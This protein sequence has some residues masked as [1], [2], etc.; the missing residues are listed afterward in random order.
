MI[1]GGKVKIGVL[2]GIGPEAT[3]EFY[4]KLIKKLQ[5]EGLIKKNQDFPQIIINSIPAPELVHEDI[6]KEDLDV[7]IGGLQ[8]LDSFS[9]DI[10]VM[11]CNTIHIYYD[12]LSTFIRAPIIN[13]RNEVKN[14]ILSK[15]YKKI[16]VLG[17]KNTL[18]QGLY[19]FESINTLIPSLEEQNILE[20]AIFNYNLGIEKDKQKK[21]A[22][23]ICKKYQELGI[24]TIILGCTEFAVMLSGLNFS[25][26]NTIDVLVEATLNIFKRRISEE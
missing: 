19:T 2:G 22:E 17:T 3:S 14:E 10:I 9:P 18:K 13:L 21:Q 25:K 23:E 15:D 8:E 7:Y 6:S 26:I 20:K 24:K 12:Y 1:F 5:S 16:L 4:N 11:V